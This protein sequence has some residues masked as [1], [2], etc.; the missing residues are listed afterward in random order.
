M[1]KTEY[2]YEKSGKIKFTSLVKTEFNRNGFI[3][4]RIEEIPQKSLNNYKYSYKYS[5]DGNLIEKVELVEKAKGYY[6]MYDIITYNKLG[7]EINELKYVEEELE[8]DISTFY[9]ERGDDHGRR[10]L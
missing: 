4:K 6:P 9:N 5:K 1:V 10:Y 2:E 8:S 7:K 3:A